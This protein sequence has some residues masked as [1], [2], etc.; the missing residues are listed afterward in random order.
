MALEKLKRKATGV[1]L[2][3]WFPVGYVVGSISLLVV[4]FLIFGGTS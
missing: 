1:V 4:L 2:H 3:K